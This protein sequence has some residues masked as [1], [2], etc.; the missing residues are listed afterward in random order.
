[1]VNLINIGE[2]FKLQEFFKKNCT[3][4][5]VFLYSEGQNKMTSSFSRKD[6]SSTLNFHQLKYLNMCFAF[7]KKYLIQSTNTNFFQHYEVQKKR[8]FKI[9]SSWVSKLIIV[10]KKLDSKSFISFFRV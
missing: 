10:D 6:I 7:N 3:Q 8:S 1:M 2:S 5:A 9:L 4:E